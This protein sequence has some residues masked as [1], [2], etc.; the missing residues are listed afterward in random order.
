[1]MAEFCGNPA[2][3]A[4]E[5]L[6]PRKRKF[7]RSRICVKCKI[8]PGNLVIRHS[9][10]CKG[11]FTPLIF[12]KFH[13]ALEPYINHVS[14]GPR[15]G[16]LKPSGAL[17][18]GFSGGLGSSVLLDLVYQRYCANVG[19]DNLKGGREHP[20]KNKVWQ[21][22]YVCYVEVS[23]IFPET[24]DRTAQIREAIAR[25]DGFELIPV[26][27]QDAFDR[28]WWERVSGGAAPDL[29]GLPFDLGGGDSE[30][31]A[32]LQTHIRA[33]PTPTAIL[34]TLSTLTRLLLLYTAYSV[35][36]SHI[37]LGTSLTSLS[38]SL[39]SSISQGGGFVVPQ[40]IQEEWFP[41]FVQRTIGDTSWNGE[42]RL[43]RP[44]RDVGMKECTAWVWWHQLLVVGKQ[45]IPVPKQTIG[46]LTKNFI[47]GLERDY[48]STVST[49]AKTVGKLAPR[50]DSRVRCVL[51]ELPTQQFVQRWKSRTSIRSFTDD[52]SSMDTATSSLPHY[53]CYS[54][55]TT[56]TSKSARSTATLNLH[57]SNSAPALNLP[58][59]AATRLAL[60][61]GSEQ[62]V[63]PGAPANEIWETKKLDD[64]GM[65]S[66]VGEFL[67]ENE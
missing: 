30:P 13:Q 52:A 59:W 66:L 28:T 60:E 6:M 2:V 1:M 22:I 57:S 31:V 27:I 58:M 12:T 7:D 21:K 23:D 38:I 67:L 39:I 15:R 54:C 62:S 16:A 63:G 5:V 44:L 10:Y 25:Y 29:A 34:S 61:L 46:D 3:E 8:N 37:V 18:I 53:L 4:G 24:S 48:P 51:C 32:A 42:V 26:R 49:I 55:H 19:S 11:C 9:V 47:I 45:R 35:S 41:Q 43:V 64:G 40:A 56:L 65:K 14:V 36:A 20:R 17:L 33:L 50:G